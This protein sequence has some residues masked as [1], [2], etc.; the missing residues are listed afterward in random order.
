[1][2]TERQT[3]IQYGHIPGLG[4]CRSRDTFWSAREAL[5]GTLG[6]CC[7][8]I[9]V[10]SRLCLSVDIPR[11]KWL[12]RRVRRWECVALD[13]ANEFVNNATWWYPPEAQQPWYAMTG[14]PTG[15]AR[16]G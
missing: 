7:S 9:T 4:E 3:A 8:Y 16:L 1:M 11:K 5:G 15:R 13:K 12:F 6:R 10:H 2:A 14:R